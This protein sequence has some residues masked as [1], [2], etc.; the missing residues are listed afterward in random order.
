[1]LEL[2]GF[3]TALYML[4]CAAPGA[5]RTGLIVQFYKAFDLREPRHDRALALLEQYVCDDSPSVRAAALWALCVF[6]PVSQMKH[7]IMRV[8]CHDVDEEVLHAAASAVEVNV[9]HARDIP[10]GLVT[11]AV[12]NAL[13][14]KRVRLDVADPLARGRDMARAAAWNRIVQHLAYVLFVV[15]KLDDPA[16][17]LDSTDS[18]DPVILCRLLAA[19]IAWLERKREPRGE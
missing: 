5:E 10:Q 4:T 13:S 6:R 19:Y 16:R 3:D 9:E 1:M 15:D 8:L 12:K 18:V 14:G 17:T 2:L 7:C 11:L